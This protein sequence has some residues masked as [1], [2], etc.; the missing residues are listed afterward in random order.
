MAVVP[1]AAMRRW[2]M[3]GEADLEEYSRK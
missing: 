1:N 2:I 3:T